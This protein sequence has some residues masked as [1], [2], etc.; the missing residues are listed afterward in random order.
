MEESATCWLAL[1]DM[2]SLLSYGTK[3]GPLA[4]GGTMHSG[5]GPSKS[6]ID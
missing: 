5:L 2:L 1:R 6:I 3:E 4:S